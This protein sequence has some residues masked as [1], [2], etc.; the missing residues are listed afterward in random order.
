MLTFTAVLLLIVNT[1]PCWSAR[2]LAEVAPDSSDIAAPALTDIVPI[3]LHNDGADEVEP[4]VV[5]DV[6]AVTPMAAVPVVACNSEQQLIMCGEIPFTDF[7]ARRECCLLN[8]NFPPTP[9]VAAAVAEAEAAQEVTA[10]AAGT[11]RPDLDSTGAVAKPPLYIYSTKCL[12]SIQAQIPSFSA[13]GVTTVTF[14][15]P[16]LNTTMISKIKNA[17]ITALKS[18]LDTQWVASAHNSL[19]KENITSKF[20]HPGT[21]SG[22]GELPLLSY[23]LNKT[24]AAM[25]TSRNSL[26]TG[27]GVPPKTYSGNW[28]A[29]TSTPRTGYTGPYSMRSVQIKYSGIENNTATCPSNYPT[30]APLNQCGHLSWLELDAVQAYRN[31]MA[32]WATNDT[33]YAINAQRYIQAWVNTNTAWGLAAENGPLE[34]SWGVAAMAKALELLKYKS[35]FTGYNATV[36]TRFISWFK[37]VPQPQI[38]ATINGAANRAK[39]KTVF[40]YNNWHSSAAEALMSLAI[41]SDNVTMYNQSETLFKATVDDYLRWGRGAYTTYQNVTRLLGECTETLR[42]IFHSQFGLA[43]LIQTAELAWQQNRDLYSYSS[44]A[45]AASMELHARIIN[46]GSSSTLLPPGYTFYNQSSFPEAP[47]PA[48]PIGCS[49]KWEMATQLWTAYNSTGGRCNYNNT[50]SAELRDGKKYVVGS[51]FLPTAWEIGFNHYVGRL[52]MWLPET[53]ALISK[54]WPDW[55]EFHWG[56]TTL[57]HADSATYLWRRGVTN[58]T[59]CVP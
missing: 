55:Y 7:Q 43:G 34:A 3:A 53:A 50:N 30:G 41:L 31:A 4:T 40:A 48:A 28:S 58:S 11:D 51:K 6:Q 20:I 36:T 2:H 19:R 12:R 9:E 44:Y 16:I 35:T 46:A 37:A 29:P 45:I 52:G 1:Q 8:R 57:T 14:T 17:S 38:E 5:E 47:A 59:I 56:L 54:N 15:V 39:N 13:T 42:D 10:A 27:T 23:R 18:S 32:W 21:L 33:Q 49:W 25:I 22:P 26:L 24:I